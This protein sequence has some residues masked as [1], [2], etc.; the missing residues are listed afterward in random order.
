[1]KNK[2]KKNNN[3]E[4]NKKTNK[5]NL[6]SEKDNN[7]TKNV[8]KKLDNNKSKQEVKQDNK[9]DN[10]KEKKQVVEDKIEI[11]NEEK[12]LEKLKREKPWVR[13]IRT[14]KQK[15]LI[16]RINTILLVVV[17]IGLCVFL[18]AVIRNAGFSPIDLS[19]NKNYSLT[20][21]SKERVSKV[22][23]DVNIYFVGWN[24]E[25]QDYILAK[26]YTNA[27]SKIKVQLIDAT[28]DIAIAKK[29]EVE[30]EEMAII[31]ECGK[32]SRKLYQSEIV[33]YDAE[34]NTVDLIEQKLTSAILNVTAEKI[35]KVYYLNG[36]S[37]YNFK[38]GLIALSKYLDDEVLTYDELNILNTG[39]VP[40][41]CDTLI[42]MTPEK[43][44]DNSATNAILEYIKKGLMLE[45]HMRK[46]H[47]IL[48]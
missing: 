2:D 8:N 26:Q 34:Y 32:T 42:I 18:N 7:K 45:L 33:T 12:S 37:S 13:F 46:I 11:N 15:W 38:K 4:E 28:K 17:L 10:K 35:P 23:K 29:Y 40:E 1:M 43:D 20:K 47:I 41:D 6:N 14:I 16:S 19:I 25:N 31:V 5:K 27:N 39:K 44:F 30:N 36:Y 22:D 9:Q 21:E 48:F 3:P 24:E